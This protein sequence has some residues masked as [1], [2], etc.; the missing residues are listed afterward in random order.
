MEKEIFEKSKQ[1]NAN[2][3][4]MPIDEINLSFT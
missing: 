4:R 2:L 3:N 1:I